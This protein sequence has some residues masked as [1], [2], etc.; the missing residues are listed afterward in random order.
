[1]QHQQPHLRDQE[2]NDDT[3]ESWQDEEDICYIA[4]QVSCY[5]GFEGLPQVHF[6]A[7]RQHVVFG[8]IIGGFERVIDT[9][10]QQYVSV[11]PQA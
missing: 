11:V 8:I 3:V 6:K 4:R 9:C 1:M 7:H 10:T 2:C 5:R